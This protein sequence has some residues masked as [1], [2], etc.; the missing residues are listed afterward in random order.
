M[1]EEAERKAARAPDAPLA[2]AWL[3][4]AATYRQ[5]ARLLAKDANAKDRSSVAVSCPPREKL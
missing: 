3:Q 5:L 2:E 4:L 1:A